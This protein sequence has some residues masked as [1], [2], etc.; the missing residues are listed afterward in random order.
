[1]LGCAGVL[2]CAPLG[3]LD[4]TGAAREELLASYAHRFTL[5]AYVDDDCDLAV[6]ES[7][8]RALVDA[9]KPAHTDVDLRIAVPH[10]RIDLE[11][12]IGID[13]ILGDDRSR[14]APLGTTDALGLPSPVLGRD[15]VLAA[16]LGPSAL[17]E[18]A[19]PSIGDF[20]I[21]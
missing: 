20:S 3:G 18:N 4:V 1:V 7:S 12:T 19:P 17:A 9:I 10:G 11:T 15:A 16:S 6:A 8:L 13:F 21:R 2:G 14:P 5:V